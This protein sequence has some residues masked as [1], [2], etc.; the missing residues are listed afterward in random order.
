M[1]NNLEKEKHFLLQATCLW[2][3]KAFRVVLSNQILFFVSAWRALDIA[4]EGS[5]KI[6]SDC[7]VDLAGHQVN[8]QM[9]SKPS[10][11]RF[12]EGFLQKK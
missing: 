5:C 6:V 11:N 2:S 4:I 12:V 3:E 8:N 1:P 9:A 7:S 10:R